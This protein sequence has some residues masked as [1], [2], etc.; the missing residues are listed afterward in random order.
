MSWEIVVKLSKM[1]EQ[2]EAH[3]SVCSF[4]RLF[5]FLAPSKGGA[6]AGGP[7][8][9]VCPPP[10]PKHPQ[11]THTYIPCAIT[12]TPLSFSCCILRFKSLVVVVRAAGAAFAAMVLLVV[13]AAWSFTQALLFLLHLSRSCPPP[14]LSSVCPLPTP[15][16]P[17]PLPKPKLPHRNKRPNPLAITGE[18][19]SAVRVPAGFIQTKA[20]KPKKWLD[21]GR[22]SEGRRKAK[23]GR[24]K[25]GHQS[26]PPTPTLSFPAPPTP[27]PLPPR[28]ALLLY[29]KK[30]GRSHTHPSPT[31]PYYKRTHHHDTKQAERQ[32]GGRPCRPARRPLLLAEL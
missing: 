8:R 9:E 29:Q 24:D 28:L 14:S 12:G 27:A 17:P 3:A 6:A 18:R 26:A 21:E 7:G 22:P 30:H 20:H 10:K 23:E 15:N 32:H 2:Q 25:Q 13:V 4:S 5:F 1:K 11:Q 31:H 19:A 16:T